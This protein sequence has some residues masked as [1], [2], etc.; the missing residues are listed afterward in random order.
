[1]K[2]EADNTINVNGFSFACEL[3]CKL[4]D[5]LQAF[6]NGRMEGYEDEE[7]G[8]QGAE[9]GFVTD[10]GEGFYV[11]ARWGI[12]RLGCLGGWHNPR[13]AEVKSFIESKVAGN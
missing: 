13:M 1:M 6:P 2:I 3:S 7:K 4:N 10:N 11:Y 12:A 9:I 5:V 8:Y